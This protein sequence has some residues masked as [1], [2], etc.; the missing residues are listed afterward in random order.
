MMDLSEQPRLVKPRPPNGL[1]AGGGKRRLSVG[2]APGGVASGGGASGGG[3]SGG[4]A[5]GGG[6][7][8]RRRR[9]HSDGPAEPLLPSHF[10]LGG[11]IHDPLNLNSLLDEEVNRA[12][13]QATPS[14]SPLPARSR[15]PVQILVPRDLTD[16]LNLKGSGSGSGLRSPPRSRRRRRPRG[17]GPAPPGLGPAPWGLGPA[18]PPSASASP[19][20]CELNT[21]ITSRD[22]VAP[23]PRLP[24][25]HSHPPAGPRG[26]GPAPR[27][28]GPAPRGSG[29][30]PRGSGPAPRG[31]GPAPRRRTASS[32]SADGAR[33]PRGAGPNPRGAGPNQPPPA[34]FQTPLVGG[35]S[36]ARCGGPAR[37][38]QKKR[39][40]YGH[41]RYYGYQGGY[42]GGG[43]GRVGGGEDP[44]LRLLQPDWFRDKTV[45]EVGCGAGHLALA[46][47]RRFNPAHVLGVE[48]DARLVHAARQNV[49]HFLSHDL[50]LQERGAKGGGG[51]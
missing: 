21:A 15:D 5:S 8:R 26:L 30:A 11:N 22:D 2:V 7:R 31:L 19:L 42:G 1:A 28:S 13:N 39:E 4:G 33:G 41:C 6:A 36:A 40:R 43:E 18:P 37:P 24:R 48:L 29:P 10:L 12:T 38:P 35:A 47:A 25:R 23:P 50:L 44:R 32:R 51:A 3:A 20:P 16:P 17:S 9:Y 27:G 49:R 45:L 14:C 46:I 34:R